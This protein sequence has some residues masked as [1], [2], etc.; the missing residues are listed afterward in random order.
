MGHESVDTC[1]R[2]VNLC[3]VAQ[4]ARGQSKVP[5]G[6]R[7]VGLLSTAFRETVNCDMCH[8]TNCLDRC[9]LLMRALGARNMAAARRWLRP[10]EDGWE[11]MT[12][13]LQQVPIYRKAGFFGQRFM[14][15]YCHL[16]R[17]MSLNLL[18]LRIFGHAF[19]GVRQCRTAVPHN[20]RDLAEAFF[21][22]AG[23]VHGTWCR[24]R[25]RRSGSLRS[26][27]R[28][29]HGFS[30]GPLAED[31]FCVTG[32]TETGRGIGPAG[33]PLRTQFRVMPRCGEVNRQGSQGLAAALFKFNVWTG[34]LSHKLATYFWAS[35]PSCAGRSGARSVGERTASVPVV[36]G[37]PIGVWSARL[38]PIYRYLRRPLPRVTAVYVHLFYT[39]S[40]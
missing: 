17:T 1:D 13:G 35:I 24:N 8:Q 40:L 31:D 37:R 7:S 27:C 29:A 10:G 9:I 14:W 22:V 34:S 25:K 33:L 3:R 38:L 21:V 28:R 12:E 30:G 36:R 19:T 2:A 26:A 5:K 32:I 16:F 39:K 18:G 23:G 4:A 6:S 15:I 20:R 11:R